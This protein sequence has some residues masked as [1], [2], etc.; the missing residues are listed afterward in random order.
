MCMTVFVYRYAWAWIPISVEV[1]NQCQVTSRVCHSLPNF[2]R[3]DL[4]QNVELVDV[5]RLAASKS[6]GSFSLCF[7]SVESH[8]CTMDCHT[9]HFTWMPGIQHKSLCSDDKHLTEPSPQRHSA[10]FGRRS[11]AS[12]RTTTVPHC[13][14][15]LL[16]CLSSAHPTARHSLSIAPHSCLH[17]RTTP[18]PPCLPDAHTPSEHTP[19]VCVYLR[20]EIIIG[21]T[22]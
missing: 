6:Q 19:T 15:L 4:W 14:V 7:P 12:A 1:R 10:L 21:H 5:A 9:W 20:K 3:Q 18:D 13:S 22:H 17:W 16:Q 2:L 11:P 8:V